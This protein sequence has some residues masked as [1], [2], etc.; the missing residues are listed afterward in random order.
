MYKKHLF[1]K[2]TEITG[3]SIS[4]THQFMIVRKTNF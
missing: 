4:M 1:I 2:K 3:A